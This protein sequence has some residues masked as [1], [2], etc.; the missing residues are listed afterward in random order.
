MAL[1]S[2]LGDRDA[3]PPFGSADKFEADDADQDHVDRNNEVEQARNDQD[4]NASNQRD[5][6]LRMSDADDMTVSF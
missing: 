6:E 3:S 5:N 4:E 1:K 2:T